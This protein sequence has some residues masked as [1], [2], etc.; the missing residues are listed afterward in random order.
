MVL[1]TQQAS[2]TLDEVV[3]AQRKVSV[4]QGYAKGATH[5]LLWG[6]LWAI[7]Y[8]GTEFFPARAGVL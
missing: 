7:G 2:E 1:T 8:A 3:A 4:L 6:V 5:F